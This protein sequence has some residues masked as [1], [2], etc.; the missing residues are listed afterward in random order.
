MPRVLVIAIGNPLRC[1]DGL[2]WHAADELSRDASPPEILR[3]HQ[4]TPELAEVVS[5]ASTVIFVDAASEGV[6]GKVA[7]GKVTPSAPDIHFSHHFTPAAILA[8][9]D[10]LYGA[11]PAAFSATMAGECFDH[12]D[13]LSPCVVEGMPVLLAK[14]RAFL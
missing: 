11:R 13:T 4:L 3:V 6:P 7:G 10:T 2:A 12:G 1:D 8:L 9:A 5:R 14:I